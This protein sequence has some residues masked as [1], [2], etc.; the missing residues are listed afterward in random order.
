MLWFI[1]QLSTDPV[2]KSRIEKAICLMFGVKGSIPEYGQLHHWVANCIGYDLVGKYDSLIQMKYKYYRQ[3]FN[4]Q[5]LGKKWLVN[6]KY[7]GW[8]PSLLKDE[9]YVFFPD[10]NHPGQYVKEDEFIY[11]AYKLTELL[12]DKKGYHTISRSFFLN[13]TKF[14]Y[15]D[16]YQKTG[17]RLTKAKLAHLNRI[18]T[19]CK[20]VCAYQRPNKTNLYVIGS[21]SPYYQLCSIVTD[22][23]ITTLFMAYKVD[24][25]GQF[26]EQCQGKHLIPGQREKHIR[27]A[28]KEIR[29][30]AAQRKQYGQN[31]IKHSPVSITGTEGT[32]NLDKLIDEIQN[33]SCMDKPYP[34][35][36]G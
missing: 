1:Q 35:V 17:R 10:K 5:K 9:D 11:M 27:Q 29:Q 6:Y 18:L 28:I 13:P 24:V 12:I 33:I 19:E 8:V 30:K 7:F 15:Q 34:T 3:H 2:I 21:E 32:S 36:K 16:Y 31:L 23:D 14:V 22:D 20:I 25:S 26:Q 4:A